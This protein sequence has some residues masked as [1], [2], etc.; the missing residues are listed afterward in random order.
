M[1]VPLAALTVCMAAMALRLFSA[2]P[3]AGPKS[4]RALS[5]KETTI[6]IILSS[7]VCTTFI[8]PSRAARILGPSIEADR[9]RAT[10]S[11]N[12]A[13]PNAMFRSRLIERTD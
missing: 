7:M 4:I 3:G 2:V 6:K 11:D 12:G 9:S 5:L 8:A 13:G 10:A 1:R